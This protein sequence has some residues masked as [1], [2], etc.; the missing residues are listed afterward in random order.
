MKVLFV[1]LFLMI[2]TAVQAQVLNLDTVKVTEVIYYD[3]HI[4]Y[5]M[6]DLDGPGISLYFTVVNTT[7]SVFYLYPSTS[8]FSIEFSYNGKGYVNVEHP[9]FLVRFFGIDSLAIQPGGSY[10]LHFGT[11]I[12]FGTDILYKYKETRDVYDY[13]LEM[14]QAL[15]TLR[16]VYRDKVSEL[17]SKGIDHVKIVRYE[18]T[19]DME[20]LPKLKQKAGKARNNKQSVP[21]K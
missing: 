5:G 16:L 9:F 12:F 1:L 3:D 13:S 11:S 20:N 4:H 15:P 7:D 6:G 21:I 18:Y 17:S 2:G 19:S 14:L 10:H 8:N